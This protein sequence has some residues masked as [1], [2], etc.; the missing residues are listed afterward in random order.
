MITY[1]FRAR[2]NETAQIIEAPRPGVWIDVDHM[3]ESDISSLVEVHQLDGGVLS[4]AQD[5]FEV[6]RFEHEKGV[7]YFFTRFPVASGSSST[8]PILIAVG[9]DFVL[10][11]VIERPAFLEKII[12]SPD[13]FTTQ[14]TKFFLQ[15]I[16]AITQEYTRVFG[17]LRKEVHRT[18]MNVRDVSER[19]IE[20][21]VH[22]EYTLNEFVTALI[23]TNEALQRLLAGSY[24]QFYEADV[25]LVEDVQLANSQLIEGAKN[26]LTT[27]QN[28]RS[29]HA[30]L[31]SN[32]LNKVVRT[33]TALTMLFTIPMV[34][35]SLYGMNIPLPL[36]AH[37]N[38][39]WIIMIIIASFMGA[40]I[41][42]I[43]RNAWI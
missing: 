31:V 29:A 3:N 17:S 19:S 22:L 40:A 11:S 27:I 38:A 25:D 16:N 10:T 39:F 8:A 26:S 5:F 41:Y 2:T 18:R 24:V 15:M 4:D 30:A 42:I 36:S 21:M 43:R 35:A 23:P 9:K 20:Q 13:I 37:D 32:Q 33:L 7:S 34:V 28:I 14:K 1:R 12:D 6:P